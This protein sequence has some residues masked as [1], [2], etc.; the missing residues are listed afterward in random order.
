VRRAIAILVAFVLAASSPRD[1]L[2]QP[3]PQ[4]Q[5]TNPAQLPQRSASF[6]WYADPQ[7]VELLVSSFA[8]R[9]LVDSAVLQ[10]LSSGIPVTIAM[11][12]Y[13]FEQ[14]KTDPVALSART[15]KVKYDLWNEVYRV[16]LT[17]PGGV[18]NLAKINVEGV[19]RD[20]FEARDLPI[21]NRALLTRGKSY[22][23][24]AIVEVNPISAAMLQQLRQWVSRPAGSTSISPGDAIF[25]SFVGLFVRQIGTSDRTLVFRTQPFPA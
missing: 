9:D 17:E 8:Y 15:C 13:V 16:E 23:L 12:A 25:G 20:C 5:L 21:V 14:G 19:L 3:T 4:A 18:R 1:A 22:F 7:G 6:A 10:K 11:R 2:A 24:G